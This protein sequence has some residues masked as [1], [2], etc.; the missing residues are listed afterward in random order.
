[1]PSSRPPSRERGRRQS[2]TAA[3]SARRRRGPHSPWPCSAGAWASTARRVFLFAVHRTRGW[4]VRAHARVGCGD[5]PL[6]ARRA[7]GGEPACATP[8]H[9]GDWRDP[10]RRRPLGS[11]RRGV[12]ARPA[13]PWQLFL[14]TAA[15]GAGWAMM[16]AAAI[17]AMVSPWFVRR[18]PAALA[19]A[20]NG[21]SVGGV[22]LS[23]LW[24]AL[25]GALRLPLA[26]GAVGGVMTL[27]LWLLAGRYF[28]HDPAAL[29]QQPDGDEV[30]RWPIRTSPHSS[31]PGRSLWRNRRFGHLALGTSL[32]LFA[33]IGLIAHPVLVS[34]LARRRRLRPRGSPGLRD[35]SGARASG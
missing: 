25:I 16:G 18:R 28:A 35:R 4:L 20:Y 32:G 23:P 30:G 22:V 5:L 14:A 9:R 3:S 10:P 13:A 2:R 21:A 34:P 15:S 12:G 33:Q 24:V 26:A 19:M 29:G 1:M 11:R 8:A 17:N 7:P 6:P 27:A 31:L